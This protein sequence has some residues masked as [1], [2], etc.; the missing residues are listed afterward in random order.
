[1]G[2]SE[3]IGIIIA[4][5]QRKNISASLKHHLHDYKHPYL[6]CHQCDENPFLPPLFH[7]LWV[8]AVLGVHRGGWVSAPWTAARSEPWTAPV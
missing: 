4:K 7:K 8:C 6:T 2:R 1:M 3:F 5:N